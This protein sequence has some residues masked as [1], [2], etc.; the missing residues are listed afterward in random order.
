MVL[1]LTRKQML[2][3]QYL[4]AK[5]FHNR[6][7]YLSKSKVEIPE[8]D[9]E[10]FRKELQDLAGVHASCLRILE[11]KNLP[12]VTGAH[13]T[14]LSEFGPCHAGAHTTPFP[15]SLD[16]YTNPDEIVRMLADLNLN[17]EEGHIHV[18]TA[19]IPILIREFNR[20]LIR[21]KN[22][23]FYEADLLENFV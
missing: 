10:N 21:G 2:I 11:N 12:P 1:K 13:T 4:D 3:T 23:Y 16:K 6:F 9:Y 7:I 19:I 17:I 22:S 14:P 5:F 8:E 20:V 18:S 15:I